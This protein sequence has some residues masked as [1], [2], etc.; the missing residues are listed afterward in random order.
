MVI[1]T[2]YDIG[3]TVKFKSYRACE[4]SV[5]EGEIVRI[6]IG[7]ECAIRYTIQYLLDGEWLQSDVWEDD[8]ATLN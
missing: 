8:L 5:I 1:S 4:C 3:A 6:T 7:K 2:K